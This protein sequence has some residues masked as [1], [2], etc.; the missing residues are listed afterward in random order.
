MG[1]QR[2]IW[3]MGLLLGSACAGRG[4][5]PARVAAGSGGASW[6]LGASGQPAWVDR[7]SAA[8]KGDTG[9]TFYGVGA[10]SGVKEPALLRS[11]ADNRARAEL[12]KVLATFTRALMQD[13]AGAD[14]AQNVEQALKTVTAASLD[15]VEV[16][17]RYVG[18]DGTLY[19]LAALDAERMGP[20][21]AQ[22]KMS[23]LVRSDVSP[24][25]VNAIF[26]A[27]AQRQAAIK[28]P[29]QADRTAPSPGPEGLRP[30]ATSALA[31]SDSKPDWVDGAS[32]QFPAATYLCAV[33]LAPERAAAETAAYAALSR[34]FRLQVQATT[35]DLMGAYSRTG[36]PDLQVQSTAAVTKTSTNTTLQGVQVEEIWTGPDETLYAL[37]CLPRLSV[38][39]LLRQQI[40]DADAKVQ[41][42]LVQAGQAPALQKVQQLSRAMDVLLIREAANAQLRIVD[43]QGIGVASPYAP[44][45]LS[46]AYAQALAALRMGVQVQGPYDGDFRTVLMAALSAR[47]YQV[48][49]MVSSPSSVPVQVVLTA[50]IRMEDAG[51]GRG[52]A[53]ATFFARGLVQVDVKNLADGRIVTVFSRSQKEGARSREDAERRAVRS[54]AASLGEDV[55]NQVDAALRR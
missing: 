51:T 6:A 10:A 31:R 39:L 24:A 42:A 3:A 1:W 49:D 53:A 9:R 32:A 30:I 34:I 35:S 41:A 38:G 37:A 2:G 28:A 29:L 43:L 47:G 36:A 11:A 8:I 50:S 23:G 27:H 44:A 45:D 48:V 13:H 4:A 17:D 19:A 18:A 54:L 33:G 12:A 20:A 46:A 14:G 25:T 22:A 7:G 55:A 5:A 40:G 16:V 52:M 26:D 21:I 15:G